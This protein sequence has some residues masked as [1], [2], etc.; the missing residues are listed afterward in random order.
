L[1]TDKFKEKFDEIKDKSK[2]IYMVWCAHY[3]GDKILEPYFTKE[4]SLLVN[5]QKTLF[6]LINTERIAGLGSQLKDGEKLYEEH[7]KWMNTSKSNG[8]YNCE[9]TNISEYEV[10]LGTSYDERKESLIKRGCIVINDG[11]APKVMVYFD[12]SQDEGEKA[13]GLLEGLL[14]WFTREQTAAGD[15]VKGG[16]QAG[17]QPTTTSPN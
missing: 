4:N 14:R 9:K 16:T 13:D 10:A 5:Q 8:R 1:D 15:R 11:Y 6:R 7:L 12:S 2:D 3:G 17:V